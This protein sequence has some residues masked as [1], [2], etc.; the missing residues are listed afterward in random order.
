MWIANMSGPVRAYDYR[1]RC[2]S[3]WHPRHHKI[4]GTDQYRAFDLA[5]THAGTA[6]FDGTQAFPNDTDF[7]S[8]Q[9]ETR[10]HRFD[11]RFAVDVL[12]SQQTVRDAHEFVPAEFL[13][14]RRY[15][16]RSPKCNRR[17]MTASA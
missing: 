4:V 6:Q 14:P 5:K 11:V 17:C 10:R 3:F 15:F 9:S 2:G 16:I 1:S 12:L 13:F 7:A 8:G